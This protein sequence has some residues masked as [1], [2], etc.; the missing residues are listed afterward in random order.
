VNHAANLLR[1]AKNH[2]ATS[3]E[4]DNIWERFLSNLPR[5][6][7]QARVIRLNPELHGDIPALDEVKAMPKLGRDVRDRWRSDMKIHRVALQ[8]VATCFYFELTGSIVE[9]TSDYT[10]NGK[11]NIQCGTKDSH[12]SGRIVC[13]LQQPREILELGK[14]FQKKLMSGRTVAFV[15][16]QREQTASEENMFKITDSVV[17]GMTKRGQFELLT[18]IHVN[19]KLSQVEILLYTD[20]N[21]SYP[22]SGFPRLLI[23]DERQS[24]CKFLLNDD[25]TMN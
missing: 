7:R 24:S 21:H 8:L 14:F 11:N 1:L 20:H 17:N 25:K 4:C 12:I 22:I 10:A 6:I 16:K 18:S 19:N 9:N 5:D 23:K 13:R 15:I 2:M 3:I